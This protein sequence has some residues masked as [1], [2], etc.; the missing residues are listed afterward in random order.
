MIFTLPRG[1]DGPVSMLTDDAGSHYTGSYASAAQPSRI[2]G[3][4]V[5]LLFRLL[6]QSSDAIRDLFAFLVRQFW[7]QF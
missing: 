6:L 1:H 5:I 2:D 4:V 3:F 7:E